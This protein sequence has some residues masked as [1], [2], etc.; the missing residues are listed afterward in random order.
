MVSVKWARRCP[1]RGLRD[2][3]VVSLGSKLRERGEEYGSWPSVA[4]WSR[5]HHCSPRKTAFLVAWS[6]EDVEQRAGAPEG[7]IY[8]ADFSLLYRVF[9]NPLFSVVGW[10]VSLL[11]DNFTPRNHDHAR[12]IR[13]GYESTSWPFNLAA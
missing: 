1:S 3:P 7:W 8:F 13:P 6:K 10:V 12:R 11:F 9:R 5:R 4:E 2:L